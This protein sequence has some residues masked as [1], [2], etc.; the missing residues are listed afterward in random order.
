MSGFLDT[1]IVVSYLTGDPP[2]LAEQAAEIIDRDENLKITD[3][4]IVETAYVLLSV[5]E[6]EREVV[7]DNLITFMQKKNISPFAL[8]KSLVLQALLLCRPSR[9]VSFADAMIWATARS[10][11]SKIIYSLDDRFPS[12][13]IKILKGY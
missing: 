11:G 1:S 13:G 6:I 2:L 8:K 7:V 12:D 10:A 3:V 5:Y 9:R 4:V